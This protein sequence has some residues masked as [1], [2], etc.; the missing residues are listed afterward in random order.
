MI[1]VHSTSVY[2]RRRMLNM[3]RSVRG[4]G[5]PGS[6]RRSGRPTRRAAQER[7]GNAAGGG[8]GGRAGHGV[9]VAA[10]RRRRGV[11]VARAPVALQHVEGRV[12]EVAAEGAGAA[13]G[14]EGGRVVVGGVQGGGQREVGERG[15]A[16]G[17]VEGAGDA[18]AFALLVAERHLDAVEAEEGRQA[19]AAAAMR[20]DVKREKSFFL[21]EQIKKI[22]GFYCLIENYLNH[23]LCFTQPPRRKL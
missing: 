19:S 23:V 16:E 21:I 4:R 12:G 3:L 1:A 15:L 13:A 14:G 17:G 20:W 7:A 2:R 5:V 8:G 6:E 11:Q 10:R 18:G 22:E 9:G